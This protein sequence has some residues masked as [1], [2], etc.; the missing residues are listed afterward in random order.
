MFFL[1]AVSFILHLVAFFFLVI[2]Y[3]KIN[4]KEEVLQQIINEKKEI[5]DLL[6]AYIEEMKAENQDLK[7]W[8][9]QS[10]VPYTFKQEES[11]KKQTAE[12]NTSSQGEIECMLPIDEIKDVS[13]FSPAMQ[14]I[15]FANQGLSIEEIAKKMNKGKGEVELLLKF[16][17][18]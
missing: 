15:S 4:Q 6:I 12:I 9:N 7:E 13:D 16:H 18:K 17:K 5:E 2:L 10:I 11:S 8:M 1:L 3:Q 14:A